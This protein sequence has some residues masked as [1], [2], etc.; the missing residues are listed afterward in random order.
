MN[1]VLARYELEALERRKLNAMEVWAQGGMKVLA[2]AMDVNL[3][4]SADRHI[5]FCTSLGWL[6]GLTPA[7]MEYQVGLRIGSKLAQGAAVYLVTG[8]LTTRDFNLHGYT[9]TPGGLDTSSPEYQAWSD[10]DKADYPPGPGVPQWNIRVSQS[11]LRLIKKVAPGEKF[12][13]SKSE[14]EQLH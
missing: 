3:A 5:G 2:K 6:R 10:K 13:L 14:I 1:D 12:M 4:P 9:Q 8:T 11:R 7:E